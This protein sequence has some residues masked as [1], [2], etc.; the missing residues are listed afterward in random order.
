MK[1]TK[2]NKQIKNRNE[3]KTKQIYEHNQTKQYKMKSL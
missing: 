2:K 1:Y 3:I